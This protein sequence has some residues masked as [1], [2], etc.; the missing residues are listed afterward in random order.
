MLGDCSENRGKCSRTLVKGSLNAPD[1]E[2]STAISAIRMLL[3]TWRGHSAASNVANNQAADAP[4]ATFRMPGPMPDD[5]LYATDPGDIAR[6]A[7]KRLTQSRHPRHVR[8]WRRMTIAGNGMP[9][10]RTLLLPEAIAF[11]L[12]ISSRIA[13]SLL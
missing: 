4:H 13:E 12:A 2:F 8:F 11:A 9:T 5:P 6:P 1:E 10:T 7:D 3:G